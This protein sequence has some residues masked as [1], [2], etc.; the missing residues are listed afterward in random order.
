MDGEVLFLKVLQGSGNHSFPI[1]NFCA[2]ISEIY[3]LVIS[4]RLM[5]PEMLPVLVPVALGARRYL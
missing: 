5:L 4:C 1:E 3:T 2:G